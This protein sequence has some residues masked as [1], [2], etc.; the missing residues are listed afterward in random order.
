MTSLLKKTRHYAFHKE[1]HLAKDERF[2]NDQDASL[3]ENVKSVTCSR[4]VKD[5]GVGEDAADEGLTFS[6]DSGD[7]FVPGEGEEGFRAL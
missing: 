5:F 4:A 2:A 7:V 3:S 6:E 1:S